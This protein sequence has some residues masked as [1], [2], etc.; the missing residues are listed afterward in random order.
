ME[1]NTPDRS[2]DAFLWIRE[3]CNLS[4]QQVTYEQAV[5]VVVAYID[6]RPARAHETFEFL[7]FE[8]LERAWPCGEFKCGAP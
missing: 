3:V 1:L 2:S 5:R 8:A 7:A 6:Q 4:T